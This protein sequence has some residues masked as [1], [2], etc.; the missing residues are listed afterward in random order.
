MYCRGIPSMRLYTPGYGHL[1]ALACLFFPLAYFS[2]RRLIRFALWQCEASRC[3]QHKGGSSGKVED[4]EAC[5]RRKGRQ[6]WIS[7][8]IA[9]R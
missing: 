8:E 9:M 2:A 6:L 7:S 4:E 5:E 1:L 3:P